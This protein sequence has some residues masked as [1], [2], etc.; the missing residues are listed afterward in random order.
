VQAVIDEQLRDKGPL[1]EE[2]FSV[3]KEGFIDMFG[4]EIEVITKEVKEVS[5]KEPRIISKVDISDFKI[6]GY[7]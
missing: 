1:I 7:A 4:S 6:S 5:R 3:L 2:I